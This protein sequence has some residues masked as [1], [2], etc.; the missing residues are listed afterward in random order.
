[1]SCE[2]SGKSGFTRVTKK[3]HFK[4]KSFF[5]QKNTTYVIKKYFYTIEQF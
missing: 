2:K 4:A 3:P 5:L 1:M